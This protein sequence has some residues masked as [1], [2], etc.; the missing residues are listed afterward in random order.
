MRGEY[1]M[2]H[3][4]NENVF[5]ITELWSIPGTFEK[6]K[7]YRL[8]VLEILKPFDPEF[9]FYTHPFSWAYDSDE[10][11]FPKGMEV[12]RFKDEQTA[13]DAIAAIQNSGI[14]DR[15]KEVFHKIR[16]YIGRFAVQNA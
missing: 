14:R 1:D 4:T 2:V 7:E 5:L 13:R 9:V 11:D 15:E 3:G 12:C 10:G 8:E 6:F 16:S